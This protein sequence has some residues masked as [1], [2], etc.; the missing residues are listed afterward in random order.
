MN[1][2]LTAEHLEREAIVYIRQSTPNQKRTSLVLSG[3]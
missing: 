1:P 3:A 2:K